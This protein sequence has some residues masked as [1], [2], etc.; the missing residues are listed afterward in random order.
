[1]NLIDRLE[2]LLREIEE[3]MAKPHSL[4]MLNSLT[5]CK[6]VL[7]QIIAKLRGVK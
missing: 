3:E 1:M 5:A 4:P 2:A 6:D 7:E